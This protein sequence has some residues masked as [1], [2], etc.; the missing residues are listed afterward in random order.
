MEIGDRVV[1]DGILTGTLKYVGG[2]R[3]REGRYAGIELDVEC[4][5]M[6][7]SLDGVLYFECRK[8]RGVVRKIGGVKKYR[9]SD[10]NQ[11]GLIDPSLDKYITCR[12]IEE[13]EIS[14]LCESMREGA[15][16][17]ES[18]ES[19]MT[20]MLEDNISIQRTAE[21]FRKEITRLAAQ[22]RGEEEKRRALEGNMG[23]ARTEI[24]YLRAKFASERAKALELSGEVKEYKIR[25]AFLETE[26]SRL[27]A[28]RAQSPTV[29]T[30]KVVERGARTELL[31]DK[32]IYQ[33]IH[34]ITLEF[35]RKSEIESA[36][37]SSLI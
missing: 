21:E 22:L 9:E 19:R 23:L 2:I 28:I 26:L 13:E 7:G 24:E 14:T 3:G 36:L 34:Q 4:G 27:L 10:Y 18:V 8:G 16:A 1:A 12:S 31:E 5:D 15:G 29:N 20:A 6:D 11:T 37:F 35:K 33:L 17:Q 25:I 32:T 30:S